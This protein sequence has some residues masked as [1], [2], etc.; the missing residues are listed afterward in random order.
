VF[1]ARFLPR[2]MFQVVSAT[3]ALKLRLIWVLQNT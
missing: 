2:S 1:L 3:S